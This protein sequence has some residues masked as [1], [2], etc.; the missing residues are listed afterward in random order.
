MAVLPAR[1]AEAA[2]DVVTTC[3]GSASTPGSLPYEVT[4]ALSGDTIAFS[5]SC[6]T[7][8]PIDLASTIDINENLTIGGPGPSTMVVSGGGSVEVFDVESGATAAT[9]SGLT[10]E[11][12]STESGGGGPGGGG[13]D[14]DG[15]LMLIDSTLSDNMA[16]GLLG[17]NGGGIE[18]DGTLTVTG[19]TLSGNTAITHA[20]TGGGINNDGILTLTDSTLSDNESM[21][22]GDIQNDVGATA[23]MN[24]QHTVGR[25]RP[26]WRRR[27]DRQRRHGETGGHDRGRQRVRGG[28]RGDNHRR[29]VQ[30]RRRRVL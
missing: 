5:V 20:H 12:G 14:N 29:R 15:T 18:N 30:P 4:N 13:I 9:I 6:P 3:S 22:G 28:L 21:G 7:T 8:S 24:Q 26:P 27:R 25:L 1:V 11:D 16:G 2:T 19:S 23:T 10:I 17:G